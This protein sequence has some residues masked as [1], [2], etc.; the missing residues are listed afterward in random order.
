ME[1]AFTYLDHAAT[2]PV[3][4][5]AQ[6]ALLAH[7]GERYGNP[8]SRHGLGLDAL[9]AVDAARRVLAGIAAC[10]PGSV[11]FT[12]GGTEGDVLALRGALGG[13]TG[14]GARPRHVVVSAI[15]HD[16]VLATARALERQ[17]HRLSVVPVDRGGC[18][19]PAAFAA[20]AGPDTAVAALMAV[21]NELGSVQPVAE[22]SRLVTERA[23]RAVF[24]VDAVQAFG[25]L[26]VNFRDWPHVDTIAMSAHKI[27]GPKGVGALFVRD[28]ARLEPLLTGGGQEFGLRSGT[29][30]V[31]GIA[32][33]AAAARLAWE[34]RDADLRHYAALDALLL[35]RLAERF[36]DAGVNGPRAALDPALPSFAA[37]ALRGGGRVPYIVNLRLPGLP[38]EP[39]LNGLE[40]AG[41]YVST[42]SA[43]HSKSGALSP[44]LAAIGLTEA[45]GGN[46]RVSVGRSTTPDEVTRVVAALAELA[47]RLRA[48]ARRT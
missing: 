26:P 12:G 36:P 16:A 10:P 2:T 5:E 1:K 42:G 44:V 47:P 38:S 9:A 20:A 25:R 13:A 35:A 29:H 30:N 27:Y 19:D 21:S 45:G 17:G 3:A 22:T 8:S 39:L 11:I 7:L 33:L 41:F 18:V 4:P 31:P 37:D 6:A 34:R 32:A 40:G 23:P 14:A 48:A 15:E 43:C 28:V 24:H 46:L